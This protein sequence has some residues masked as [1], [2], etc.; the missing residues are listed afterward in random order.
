[1]HD[2][3]KVLSCFPASAMGLNMCERSC[4]I[5][6]FESLTSLRLFDPVHVPQTPRD[7]FRIH[8]GNL[9]R[10]QILPRFP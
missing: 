2:G 1:M 8:H 6:L 5:Q 7:D 10:K 3:S 9:P 4:S